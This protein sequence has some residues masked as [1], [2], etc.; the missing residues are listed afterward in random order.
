MNDRW[1]D[2]DQK[3]YNYRTAAVNGKD[4]FDVNVASNSWA[5]NFLDDPKYMRDHKNMVM[6]IEY[7]TPKEY[8]EKC[9]KDVFHKPV[10]ALLH[11]WRTLDSKTLD[12][13]K[14][15]IQIYK[16]KFPITYIDYAH[17]NGVVKQEG[18]HRMIVAGDLFGW[19]TKFPVM[20]IEWADK[21][22]AEID[23]INKRNNKISNYIYNAI[24][25]AIRYNY[26]NIDDLKTQLYD[27]I[28]NELKYDDEFENKKFNLELIR[29]YAND[30]YNVIVNNRYNAEIFDDDIKLIEKSDSEG[31][32]DDILNDEDL[33]DWLKE[34]LNEEYAIPR[35][36]LLSDQLQ[37]ELIEKFGE[38]YSEKPI[39]KEVCEYIKSKCANCEVLSFAIGVWKQIGN[40]F[41][42]IS[43]KGHC[44]IR[45]NDVIYDYTSN[46]YV[47][48]GID[49]SEGVRVLTYNDSLSKALDV[50][51]YSKDNYIIVV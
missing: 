25:R 45:L 41:E 51:I 44:V 15:V 9:A 21:H 37:K 36:Y 7:M 17:D 29:N 47:D 26:Y 30:G 1:L 13:L 6:H 48:Y 3:F 20:I 49:Y 40:E 2:K 8:W 16:R 46:Q 10:S 27:E 11:Q 35:E 22:K 18:L 43:N 39:C 33:S 14:Q 12:H 28:G 31:D 32:L 50:K 5:G 38:N 24:D 23:A 19:D 4:I 34:I 42:C